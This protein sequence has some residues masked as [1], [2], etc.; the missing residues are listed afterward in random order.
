MSGESRPITPRSFAVALQELGLASL[1]L[2]VVELRNS[3]AHLAYSNE[4][5]RPFAEGKAA[6]L[7]DSADDADALAAAA[8]ASDAAAPAPDQ[9]CVD[10]IHENEEVIARMEERIDLIR[11]ELER[12]GVPLT[13]LPTK[14]EIDELA[15]RGRA[16][17]RAEAAAAPP[18]SAAATTGTNGATAPE[19]T[20]PEQHPAWRDGTFQTLALRGRDSPA[21]R[22]GD[23]PAV[24]EA[25]R[26]VPEAAGD[27]QDGGMH[28]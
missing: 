19:G 20:S 13:E 23:G 28:L 4:Q 11:R 18:T 6:A 24:G 7:P 27:D 9:D 15:A 5:L 25:P 26:G 14:E 21:E 10:A 1:H 16:V 3:I 8:A 17:G 12:R 22:P 2:K